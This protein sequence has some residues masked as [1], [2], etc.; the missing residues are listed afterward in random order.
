MANPQVLNL[1]TKSLGRRSRKQTKKLK[2]GKGKLVPKAAKRIQQA[3]D[4]LGDKADGTTIL[5][6]VIIVE[7]EPR[8]PW[9]WPWDMI[10]Y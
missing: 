7:R 5:P 3:I 10:K 8:R 2:K 1:V 9:P 4:D 6:V